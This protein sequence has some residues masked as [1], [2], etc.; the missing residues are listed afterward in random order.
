[1]GEGSGKEKVG[2]RNRYEKR[3]EKSPEDQDYE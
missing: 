2:G 3:Q 1:M